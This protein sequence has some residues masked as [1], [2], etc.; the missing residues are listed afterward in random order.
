[1]RDGKQGRM[2]GAYAAV[3]FHAMLCLGA[4]GCA[5]WKRQGRMRI[6]NIIDKAQP[7]KK[8]TPGSAEEAP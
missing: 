7:K 8:T 2:R 4:L 5:S 6:A 3:R 1:M